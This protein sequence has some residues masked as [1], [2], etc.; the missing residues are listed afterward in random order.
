MVAGTKRGLEET[1]PIPKAKK[2]RVGD[3]HK[4]VKTA[5]SGP[6]APVTNLVQEEVDFPRGG[7]TS[8]TPLEVKAIRAEAV[9]EANEELFHVRL[10]SNAMISTF[11]GV[12]R[13]KAASRR[14]ATNKSRR[15]RAKSGQRKM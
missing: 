14:S 9:K 8:F 12:F 10:Y 5:G 15:L 4:K 2:T 11:D 7:G 3:K 1:A 6:I 13:I